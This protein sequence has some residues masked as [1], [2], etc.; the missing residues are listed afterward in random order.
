MLIGLNANYANL[1]I[2]F[3]ANFANCLFDMMI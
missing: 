1:L 3:N 2:G